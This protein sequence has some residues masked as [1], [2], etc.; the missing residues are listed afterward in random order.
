MEVLPGKNPDLYCFCQTGRC[1]FQRPLFLQKFRI[2]FGFYGRIFNVSVI[3]YLQK[4]TRGTLNLYLIQYTPYVITLIFIL[5]PAVLLGLQERNLNFYGLSGSFLLLLVVFGANPRQF[6]YLLG[7]FFWSMLLIRTALLGRKNSAFRIWGFFLLLSALLPVILKNFILLHGQYLALY[8]ASACICLKTVQILSDI[9]KGRIRE[10]PLGECAG[11]LLFFP[12]LFLGPLSNRRQFHDSW[13]CVP[14]AV[15]Y[16]RMLLNGTQKLLE[17]ILFLLFPVPV[18]SMMLP[19]LE[20]PIAGRGLLPHLLLLYGFLYGLRLFFF[21]AGFS[22]VAAGCACFLGE[23][24]KK[25][26]YLPFF[27]VSIR[28]FWNRWQITFIC[29]LKELIFF[30]FMKV[31]RNAHAGTAVHCRAYSKKSRQISC[32]LFWKCIGYILTLGALGI[33]YGISSSTLLFAI[34]HGVLLCLSAVWEEK[35]PLH[36]KWNSLPAYR[37]VSWVLTMVLLS[38]GFSLL[39]GIFPGPFLS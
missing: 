13:N 21:L 2:S 10:Y 35:S 30:P 1:K 18:L 17:G 15:K 20:E 5:L 22:H 7:T 4:L 11:F 34:Y 27:S 12:S 23:E 36:K 26:F 3:K 25:N 6:F 39:S 31:I 28:D 14:S 33:L 32:P 24:L 8:A 37:F 9:R 16:R 29:Q 19:R 38:F